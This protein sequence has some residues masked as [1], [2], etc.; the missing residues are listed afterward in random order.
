MAQERLDNVYINSYP[1]GSLGDLWQYDSIEFMVDG[2]HSGGDYTGSADPN[3]TADE[4]VLNNN[5]TAQQYAAIA[6]SPDGHTV[7]YSGSGADWVNALPYG[8]GG[9][10]ASVNT[11]NTSIIEFFVTPFDDLIWNNP[12][13]SKVSDLVPNKIIG[14]QI[15]VPDFDAG[16]TVY[17][18]FQT[19][20][21]QSATWR[22]ADRF[23]DG[24]LVPG[25]ASTT[26][27]TP[28]LPRAVDQADANRRRRKAVA[29]ESSSW[30]EIKAW[31]VGEEQK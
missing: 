3:W 1:G 31:A 26:S 29:V 5:R 16:S 8:D 27:N 23:A 9:G 2:D 20:T 7:G 28:R 25:V 21:G 4:Q 24:R 19:L 10:A 15:S 12:G 6:T 22:Y 14:F 11:P 17:H 18:T 13:S 30:G